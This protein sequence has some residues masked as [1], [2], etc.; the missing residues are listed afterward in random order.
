[1]V[2]RHQL[3]LGVAAG[4]EHP[5]I[6]MV[7]GG[8]VDQPLG[9]SLVAGS[10]PGQAARGVTGV[11]GDGVIVGDEPHGDAAASEASHDREAAMGAAEDHGARCSALS[12]PGSRRST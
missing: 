5:V 8:E 4:K 2:L 6:E 11:L 12:R 10:R 7:A 9:R 1:V 3:R